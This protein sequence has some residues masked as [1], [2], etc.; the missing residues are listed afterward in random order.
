MKPLALVAFLLLLLP[1]CAVY[2]A[3][4]GRLEQRP[5]AAAPAETKAETPATPPQDPLS[6]QQSLLLSQTPSAQKKPD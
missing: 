4:H 2:D 1:A 3:Q 5:P 6:L